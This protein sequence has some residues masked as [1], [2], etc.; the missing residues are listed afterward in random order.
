MLYWL[1]GPAAAS[2]MYVSLTDIGTRRL[3]QG[4]RLTVPA[5]FLFCPRDVSLPPPNSL[6]TRTYDMHR[7]TDAPSGGHFLAFEQPDLFVTDVREAMRGY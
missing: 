6:I 4:E 5:A 7:R 1:Q 2:W 3:P